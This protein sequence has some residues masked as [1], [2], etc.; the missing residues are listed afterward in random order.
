MHSFQ[1]PTDLFN[2]DNPKVAI[3]QL[4]NKLQV[5]NFTIIA[6]PKVAE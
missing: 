2:S 3:T 1:V 4:Y 5:W 6:D